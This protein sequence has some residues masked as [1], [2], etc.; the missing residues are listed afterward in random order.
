M[1]PLSVIIVAGIALLSGF[2]G[3]MV[4]TSLPVN[5]LLVVFFGLVLGSVVGAIIAGRLFGSG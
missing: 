4:G 1:N 5:T 3:W 2:L